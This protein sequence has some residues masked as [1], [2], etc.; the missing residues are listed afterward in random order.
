MKRLLLVIFG[1]ILAGVAALYFLRDP[2][3]ADIALL[4]WQLH[5]TA[6]GFLALVLGLM[7]VLA[8]V[9]RL[10]ATLLRLPAFFRARSARARQKQ[11]D[12][13]LLR[14]FAES[15][16]G[17]FDEAESLAMAHHDAAS[18]GAMHFVLAADAA[19]ARGDTAAALTR[20]DQA[21]AA[22]PRFADYLALHLAQRLSTT[23]QHATAIELLQRLHSTHD[24]DEA[25]LLALAHALYAGEDWEKLHSLMP[26]I[27]RLKTA[28][29]T[30][31]TLWQWERGQLLGR[32][33]AVARSGSLDALRAWASDM[34]KPLKTDEG[35]VRAQAEAARALGQPGEARQLLERALEHAPRPA[36]LRPWLALTTTD[37][38][39]AS[40]VLQRI[41]TQHPSALDDNSRALAQA[42]LAL[43]RED[44]AAAEAALAPALHD[45]HDPALFILAAELAERQ[46]DSVRAA[47]M[48]AKALH[49][50]SPTR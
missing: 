35:I 30:E 19:L 43:H 44:F 17:R 16:R 48:Y 37:T 34:P 32:L 15:A 47:A 8:V 11:A 28:R 5:T 7:V 22:Y 13:A 27:R 24:R 20:L 40:A 36:L 6:L 26:A 25:V 41:E 21:R 42:T 29:L 33:P 49:L 12:D 1:L 10:L 46:R 4:G 39:A 38:L 2:G 31:Q 50:T 18:V 3:T 9:W 23:G 14:A 45:S